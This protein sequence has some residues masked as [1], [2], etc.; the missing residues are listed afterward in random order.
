M[1]RLEVTGAVRPI[2][3]SLGVKRLR[4]LQTWTDLWCTGKERDATGFR[5]NLEGI[6]FR[7]EDS[8]VSECDAGT[9][10]K[11]KKYRRV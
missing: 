5:I 10:S 1:Q 2:Y 3:V 7:K 9:L 8:S 4:D 11:K 6:M